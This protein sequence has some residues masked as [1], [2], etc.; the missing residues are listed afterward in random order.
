MSK[1]IQHLKDYSAKHGM[2][3]KEAMMDSKCKAAYRKV[4]RGKKIGIMPKETKEVAA[5]VSKKKRRKAMKGS[6][7]KKKMKEL[8][9]AEEKRDNE[10][11][12]RKKNAKK[13]SKLNSKEVKDLLSKHG[14][15]M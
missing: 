12:L 7:L 4:G 2:T 9:A 11:M 8:R 13:N 3:Y 10:Y 6:D 15:K 14:F 5:G 1:W